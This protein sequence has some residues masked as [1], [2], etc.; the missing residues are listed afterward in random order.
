MY[1]KENIEKRRALFRN[2]TVEEAIHDFMKEFKIN[3]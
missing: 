3:S 2:D 1:T